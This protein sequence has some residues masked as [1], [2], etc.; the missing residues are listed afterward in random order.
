MAVTAGPIRPRTTGARSRPSRKPKQSLTP[1]VRRK[2][3][4][5]SPSDTEAGASAPAKTGTT[6]WFRNRYH[7]VVP[8]RLNSRYHKVVPQG[9]VTK[10][11]HYLYR[12]GGVGDVA[13][14]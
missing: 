14:V 6:K 8:K 4:G 7:K 5:Q 9:R 3:K 11:S 13:A 10:W 1:H 2:T 12:G